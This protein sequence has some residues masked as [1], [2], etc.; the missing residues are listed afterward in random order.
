MAPAGSKGFA[1]AYHVGPFLLDPAAKLMTRDS[2]PV[3]LGPRA[4]AVLGVLVES[5]EVFVSKARLMDAAW[6]GAVVEENNLAVQ[7]AAIR[8]VLAETPGGE[9]WI[10]T[11]ARR[12]YRFVGPV[13][14]AR[15]ETAQ[16]PGATAAR[17]NL[18]E[19]LTSFVGRVRELA[20]LR[21]L[22]GCNRL[23]TLT[24]PGGVG[25]TRLALHAAADAKDDWPDGVWFVDLAPIV[26]PTL[27]PN[28]IAQ[29]L[30]LKEVGSETFAETLGSYLRPMQSLLILDNCEHLVGA[31]AGLV[32]SLLRTAPNLRF[33]VT[34][35]EALHVG[36][37]QCYQLFPLS[38]PAGSADLAALSG[39][40]AVQLFVERAR[41]Q[42]Q[43]FALTAQR[44]PAIAELCARLDG[45]PLALELAAARIGVLPVEK[46]VERLNDRFRLLTGGSRTALPRQQTLRATITWSF[47]LLSEAARTLFARL[48]VFIGGFDLEAAEAI[49]GGDGLAHDD[50]LD[51][52]SSLIDKSLVLADSGG[53]RY[54]LL[55]TIREFARER[56]LA[57][58]EGET[59]RQRHAAWY[60]R[61]AE[62]A[63]PRLAGGRLQKH[64]LD[65]LETDHDNL[66]AAL[67]WSLEAPERGDMALRFCGA[68]YRFWSRRGYWQEGYRA[69][70]KALTQAPP[71][72][73]KAARAKA[74]LTAGSIGNNVPGAESRD[75]LEAALALSREAGDRN[76]EALALNNLARVLDW[77]LDLSRAKSLLERAREINREL[78]NG[79]L[80]LHNMSNLI[81]VLRWQ[82]DPATALALAQEG[83][84][85]SR[86]SGDRWL[87][88]IFLHALGRVALDRGD[89][90][91][92]QE[93]NELALGIAR[94][95]I[96]PDWQSF[97][98]V[99]LAFLAV[100]G[101][102][103]ASARRHLSVAVDISRRFG[104]RLNLSDCFTAAGVLASFTGDHDRAVLLWG[105]ADTFL[106]S[107]FS[108]DVL[109]RDL[110]EPYRAKSR[111]AVDGA[112]YDAL[113]A[114]GRALSRQRAINQ[115]IGWLC[116]MP[117]EL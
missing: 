3:A 82:H 109:D 103:T 88:A 96:M 89:Y 75:L 57:T 74:L 86:A 17:S 62:Q 81:N 78:G 97:A 100:A 30:G 67:A 66:R 68:L 106:G 22:L 11:L 10:E 84:A 56:L 46:I 36:G 113:V 6:P 27:V 32:E 112:K 104:G 61:L 80:E 95:L 94:E 1:G 26:E 117:E 85:S 2:A 54:R 14:K 64:G 111:A 34:G 43:G 8:R 98:L 13:E 76:T 108:S 9:H 44:A 49:A 16:K 45:M 29:V 60:V 99:K 23:V 110:I 40:E 41:L 12:G 70:M 83:L 91:G 116:A 72:G 20:E 65:L 92:A 7:I 24:G 102:D 77:K 114:E 31:C 37:E 4:V 79:T 55:E 50:V 21:A 63:E 107:L 25:K 5:A 52:L 35:R 42:Q 90:A 101:G 33:L 58:R 53:R 69:C 47:D 19:A 105:V 73:D 38:L 115:A 15:E 51:L 93:C 18:P 59:I 28:A 71:L 87:E 48:S 39:S